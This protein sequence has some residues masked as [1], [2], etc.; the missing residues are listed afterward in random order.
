M[1]TGLDHKLAPEQVVPP[2]AETMYH[3]GHLL[4]LNR[5]APL[6]VVKLSTLKG[7]GMTLL[8]QDTT[9]GK[10]GSIGV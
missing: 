4:L 5:V 6:G 1:A 8:H 7:N 10:V 9:N 2:C 3:H